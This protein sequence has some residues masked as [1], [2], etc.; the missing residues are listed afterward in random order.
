MS[1]IPSDIQDAA[2]RVRS[3]I[4]GLRARD[5]AAIIARAIL[6]ERERCTQIALTTFEAGI[7]LGA[8]QVISERIRTLPASSLTPSEDMK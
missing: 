7:P 4:Y 5:G 8:G 6:A 1:D 3:D 2:D